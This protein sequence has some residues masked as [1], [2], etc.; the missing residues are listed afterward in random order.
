M[1]FFHAE[2][3]GLPLNF[4]K[5]QCAILKRELELFN[6]PTTQLIDIYRSIEDEPEDDVDEASFEG[7]NQISALFTGLLLMS[8]MNTDIPP[9]T[10]FS[11]LR[12]TRN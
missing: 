2:G 4:L 8:M 3:Q 7:S 9:T 11:N 5:G 6:V 1:K 12:I 10:C